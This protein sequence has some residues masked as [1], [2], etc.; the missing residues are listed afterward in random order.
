MFSSIVGLFI[1]VEIKLTGQAVIVFFVF[2]SLE[3]KVTT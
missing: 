3:A 2:H 1:W